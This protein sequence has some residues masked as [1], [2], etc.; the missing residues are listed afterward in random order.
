MTTAP[1]RVSRRL[2]RDRA[3]LLVWASF[4]TVAWLLLG[5]LHLVGLV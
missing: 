3:G 1:P 2:V 4:V 5:G